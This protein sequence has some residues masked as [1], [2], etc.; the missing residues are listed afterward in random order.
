M[1]AACVHTST[2]TMT[3]PWRCWASSYRNTR[4]TTGSLLPSMAHEMAVDPAIRGAMFDVVTNFYNSDMSPE[5]AAKKLAA[6]V[7]AAKM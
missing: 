1:R 5:D 7:K 3:R 4:R 6:A 2:E